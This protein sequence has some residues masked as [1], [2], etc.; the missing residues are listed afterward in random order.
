MC[1]ILSGGRG[2]EANKSQWRHALVINVNIEEISSEII[3]DCLDIAGAVPD[4]GTTNPEDNFSINMFV[5]EL[6]LIPLHCLGKVV[7]VSKLSR[8]AC[9]T[10]TDERYVHDVCAMYTCFVRLSPSFI[11]FNR[12]VKCLNPGNC[13]LHSIQPMGL[14]NFTTL[15]THIYSSLNSRNNNITHT[16]FT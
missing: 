1:R 15:N 5:W 13:C 7:I 11:C 10:N 6:K 4:T 3:L 12:K 14:R 9:V 16:F 2:H 8:W